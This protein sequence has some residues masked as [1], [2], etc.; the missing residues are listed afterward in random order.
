MQGFLGKPYRLL[1]CRQGGEGRPEGYGCLPQPLRA[2]GP[3]GDSRGAHAYGGLPGRILLAAP[4]PPAYRA[5]TP[6]CAVPPPS[7]LFALWPLVELSPPLPPDLSAT[8]H[9][10]YASCGVVGY[11]RGSQPPVHARLI[12]PM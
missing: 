2:P 12:H 8:K 3:G 4:S 10:F 7:P 6:P 5:P 1:R 9:S 11:L